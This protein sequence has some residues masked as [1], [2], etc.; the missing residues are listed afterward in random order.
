MAGEIELTIRPLEVS[1]AGAM[2]AELQDLRI[3]TFIDERPPESLEHL[4]E[5]YGVLCG[6]APPGRG[7]RWLNW[8]ILNAENDEPLGTLQAT[9]DE[10]PQR[11]SIAYVLLPKMWG[12]GIASRATQWLMD[13]LRDDYEVTEAQVE[14]HEHNARSLNLAR[15]LGFV[16]VEL[17]REGDHNEVIL[18]RGLRDDRQSPTT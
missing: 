15:R 9:I 10:K 11:A 5:R 1:D 12:R 14:I 16:D 17:R 3:Y 7:E 13:Q 4:Q 2:F 8:I 18:R 6:G